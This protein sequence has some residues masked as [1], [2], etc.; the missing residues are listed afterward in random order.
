M[1]ELSGVKV[2]DIQMFPLVYYLSV[3][4]LQ[5][6]WQIKN[7][8]KMLKCAVASEGKYQ[9]NTDDMRF[10]QRRFEFFSVS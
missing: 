7:C 2:I 9:E 10:E 8:A 3:Q 5:Y 4:V 6:T 1:E